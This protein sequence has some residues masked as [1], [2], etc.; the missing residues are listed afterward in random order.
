MPPSSS[1]TKAIDTIFHYLRLVN[2]VFSFILSEV[3]MKLL[4]LGRDEFIVKEGAFREWGGRGIKV[5]LLYKAV[6]QVFTYNCFA[7]FD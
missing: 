5:W 3:G 1:H 7:Y 2:E 6:Y 4:G